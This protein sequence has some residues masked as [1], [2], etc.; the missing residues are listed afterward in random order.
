[1]NTRFPIR[2][3]RVAERSMEPSIAEGSYAVVNCLARRFAPGDVV[4]LRNPEGGSVLI[5]RI[6]R[7]AGGRLFVVGDNSAASRDSR[8][9]GAVKP[10]SV[11]G[12]V[13]LVV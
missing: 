11:L 9:F 10:D 1:M 4:V 12:K 13:V 7:I 6:G 3:Y 5:K 8:S 2:V